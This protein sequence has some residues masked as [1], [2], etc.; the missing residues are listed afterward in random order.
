MS[1]SFGPYHILH[2]ISQ[3]GMAEVFLAER[4]GDIGGFS[5]RVAIKRLYSHLAEEDEFCSMFFDEGRITA[6]LNHPNIVQIFEM[7]RVEDTF[8]ICMEYVHGHD[9]RTVCERGLAAEQFLSIPM[10]ATIVAEASAGIHHAHT[11]RGPEGNPLGI[12]HRDISPQNI[13]VSLHGAVKVCDFGV[14]K[15]EER[16]AHTR[17]GQLKGKYAYMSPEQVS[18]V[19]EIDRR[20]DIFSLGI[21]LYETTAQT[22]LFR[23]KN[24]FDTIRMVS[25]G[26]ITPPTHIREDYPA[27]LE[28]IVL[29]ALA[30]DPDER[31]QSAQ[32]LQVA[33]EEWLIARRAQTT[34]SYM[35]Q[36]MAAL[37]PEM[38][39]A[40]DDAPA[41]DATLVEKRPE[42]D[43]LR[44]TA[45]ITPTPTSTLDAAI[46]GGAS[47][48]HEDLATAEEVAAEDRAGDDA[49]HDPSTQRDHS[50]YES[51]LRAQHAS[52][53]ADTAESEPLAEDTLD[54]NLRSTVL[55]GPPPMRAS[56]PTPTPTPSKPP[57]EEAPSHGP[58]A[59]SPPTRDM[60]RDAA[61]A[62]IKDAA[63][64]GDD[65]ETP[66]PQLCEP[67]VEVDTEPL[68]AP[69]LG[70][71]LEEATD[72]EIATFQQGDTRR[73]VLYA[74]VTLAA[75]AG[76]VVLFTS[77]GI[78]HS[79][80][81]VEDSNAVDPEALNIEPPSPLARTSIPLAT[82]PEGARVVVNGVLAEA[83][84]P[85]A[86]SLVEGRSNEVIFFAEGRRSERVRIE[87]DN[88]PGEAFELDVARAPDAESLATITVTTDPVGATIMHNGVEVGPAPVTLE[89]VNPRTL[90]HIAATK[91]GH[92]AAVALMHPVSG[93]AQEVAWTLPEVAPDAQI[94]DV[95]VRLH[96]LPRGARALVDG[97]LEGVTPT[98]EM[99]EMHGLYEVAFEAPEHA[100]RSF[101]VETRDLGAWLLRPMLPDVERAEGRVSVRVPSEAAQIYLGA[102]AYEAIDALEVMEGRYPLVLETRGGGRLEATVEVKPEAHTRY[103]AKIVNG[104]LNLEEIP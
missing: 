59:D 13:L 90:H 86:Y 49:P 88:L 61:M 8:F 19:A 39:Y 35:A 25:E 32:A 70:D 45:E 65:G 80:P 81:A 5:K 18:G 66:T 84:T 28:P 41:Q 10:A 53:T 93:S 54:E 73:R 57:V 75:V 99:L 102:N 55:R 46:L 98:M 58:Y 104:V 69:D 89:Q 101:L 1:T 56:S 26:E 91:E 3:G 87:P 11:R 74:G 96:G 78:E 4:R 76:L 60:A 37:F 15:A 43:T 6:Q 47:D 29:K 12:I 62:A 7:G 24:E 27:A 34:A 64:H 97:D 16:L 30:R 22:R 51:E 94:F 36:Y 92:R 31:Y 21:I 71:P 79:V 14:V 23:G 72:V 95:E 17:A 38:T 82:E 9:L 103:R 2:K 77:V 85:A 40:G 100:S 63:A 83:T 48:T 52:D 33:L 42:L 67:T 44:E 20:A 68:D 50:T